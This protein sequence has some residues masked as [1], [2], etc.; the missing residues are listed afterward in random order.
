MKTTNKFTLTV[1]VTIVI[2]AVAG[3]VAMIETA[4]YTTRKEVVTVTI[5]VKQ[6]KKAVLS[7]D[8]TE[9]HTVQYPDCQMTER[10]YYDNEGDFHY[11]YYCD[12]VDH[13][14]LDYLHVK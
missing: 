3:I 4:K 7:T 6:I 11:E 12:N 5:P 14:A 1:C 10:L 2:I 9:W 8:S 13:S